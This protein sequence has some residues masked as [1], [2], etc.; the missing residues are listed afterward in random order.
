MAIAHFPGERVES[1][2]LDVRLANV[3]EVVAVGVGL[4]ESDHLVIDP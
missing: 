3:E 4:G 1:R 2:V